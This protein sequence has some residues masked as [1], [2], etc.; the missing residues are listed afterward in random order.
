MVTLLWAW[1]GLA[2]NT[3]ISTDAITNEVLEPITFVLAHPTVCV[4]VCVCACVCVLHG[5]TQARS[6]SLAEIAGSNPTR[7]MDVCL[8]V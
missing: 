7:G 2:L 1:K 6:R 8:F 4:C 5:T 3:Y